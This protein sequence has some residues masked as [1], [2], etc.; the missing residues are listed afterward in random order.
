MDAVFEKD[1]CGGGR[2][3]FHSQHVIE[4]PYFVGLIPES[5]FA[6]CFD[7]VSLAN[8]ISSWV[9]SPGDGLGEISQ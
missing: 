6:N 5:L 4:F 9:G 8:L 7:D 1:T 2:D 3:W